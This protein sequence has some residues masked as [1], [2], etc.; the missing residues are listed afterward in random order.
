M[1]E[2]KQKTQ[3][4]DSGGQKPEC[5]YSRAS[6]PRRMGKETEGRVIF[7]HQKHYR[8]R[9]W[10]ELAKSSRAVAGSQSMMREMNIL[11]RDTDETTRRRNRIGSGGKGERPLRGAGFGAGRRA[12]PRGG[13]S[14]L[15]PFLCDFDLLNRVHD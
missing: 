13:C 15:K 3:L 14:S 8:G 11:F 12:R 10:G 9:A 1:T 7:G 5:G 6:Y 2:K 4:A